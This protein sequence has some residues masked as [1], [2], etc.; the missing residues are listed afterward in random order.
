MKINMNGRGWL[1]LPL[2]LEAGQSFHVQKLAEMEQ[3][4]LEE[5]SGGRRKRRKEDKLQ[6]RDKW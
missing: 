3:R 2:L 4:K 6:F 5:R 1:V